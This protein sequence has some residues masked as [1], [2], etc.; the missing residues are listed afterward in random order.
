MFISQWIQNK[1]QDTKKGLHLWSI[2]VRKKKAQ[3]NL[4]LDGGLD[5]DRVGRHSQN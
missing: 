5:G 2:G 4:L 3:G 1:K